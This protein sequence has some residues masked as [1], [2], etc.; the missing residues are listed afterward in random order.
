[1]F[2][3]WNRKIEVHLAVYLFIVGLVFYFTDALASPIY[4]IMTNLMSSKDWGAALLTISCLHMYSLWLNGKTIVV[5]VPVRLFTCVLHL[6]FLSFVF[7]SSAY[8]HIYWL[9]CTMA[10]FAV[11]LFGP[12]KGSLEKI[13]TIMSDYYYGR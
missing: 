11:F 4:S 2:W 7:I 9:S 6:T 12:I 10:L 5:S 13:K 3:N 1:M 8:N